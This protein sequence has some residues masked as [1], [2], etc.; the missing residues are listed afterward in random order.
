M[1]RASEQFDR[2]ISIMERLR[3]ENGCPWDREQD[4]RSLRPYLVEETYEVLEQ[5]DRVAQGGPMEPLCEELGDLLFQIVFH[6]QIARERGAFELADVAK[7]ICDKIEFRHPHVFGDRKLTTAAE[8]LGNWV[9]L[10]AE[11]KVRRF[12]HEG[13]AIDGVPR[14]APALMRAE[15]LGEKA[16]R[17]GFDWKRL[18]D[19][20][21]KVDEELRELDE[22]IASRSRDRIEQEL[23]DVLFAVANLGRWVKAPPEDAL[24]GTLDRFTNRFHYIE[25]TLRDRGIKPDEATLEQMDALWNEAKAMARSPST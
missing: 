12:G 13:S 15:R 5:M 3:A 17:V 9:K 18:S 2:L 4:I 20:R 11:E 25:R 14:D 22:A 16:S 19:V 23:G 6:S 10:K 1:S 7:A 21:E 24:R 8:V